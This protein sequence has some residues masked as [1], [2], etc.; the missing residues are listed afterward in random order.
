L[1]TGR[2]M[3]MGHGGTGGGA[4]GLPAMSKRDCA[5]PVVS[6]GSARSRV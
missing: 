4:L 2:K 5:A 3:E 6:L 1:Q